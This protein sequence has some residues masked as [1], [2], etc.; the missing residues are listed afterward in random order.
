MFFHGF[1]KNHVKL[2]LGTPL[3][4]KIELRTPSGLFLVVPPG[5]RFLQKSVKNRSG[6]QK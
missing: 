6:T 1:P 4:P 3:D 5:P 2:R